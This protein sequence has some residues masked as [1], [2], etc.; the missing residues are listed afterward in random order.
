MSSPSNPPET[1]PTF[2]PD[3]EP[4]ENVGR[5]AMRASK[6]WTTH[7]A[8]VCEVVDTFREVERQALAVDMASDALDIEERRR[9]T[10]IKEQAAEYA[11]EPPGQPAAARRPRAGGRRPKSPLDKLDAEAE[12]QRAAAAQ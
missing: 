4:E 3:V 6:L 2:L 7:L 1:L 8:M 5:L 12:R 10:L 9:L 11:L